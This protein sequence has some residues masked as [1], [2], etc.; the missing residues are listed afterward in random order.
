MKFKNYSIYFIFIILISFIIPIARANIILL[1]PSDYALF[2]LPLI[3]FLYLVTVI[4]EF[5]IFYL[6]FEKRRYDTK[7]LFKTIAFINLLTNPI[8]QIFGVFFMILFPNYLY[9]FIILIEVLVI[10][11]EF[12]FIIDFVHANLDETYLKTSLSKLKL[13]SIICVA[14]VISMLIGFIPLI[15]IYIFY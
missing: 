9:Y 2:F 1:G 11:L 5:V 8:A 6:A 3:P 7:T 10:L 13:L 12:I 14:N 4:I 15:V